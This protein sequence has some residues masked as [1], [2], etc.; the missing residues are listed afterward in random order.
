MV[1]PSEVRG[2]PTKRS[3]MLPEMIRQML[4]QNS[5]QGRRVV[6]SLPRD[7]VL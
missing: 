3:Q 6:A 5:F 7:I 2:D 1:V 4:R